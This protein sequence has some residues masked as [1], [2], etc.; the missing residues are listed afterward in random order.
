MLL[1]SARLNTRHQAP[2]TAIKEACGILRRQNKP[3]AAFETNLTTALSAAVITLCMLRHNRQAADLV[4][5]PQIVILSADS[6][7]GR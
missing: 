4:L 5:Q 1:T 2:F 6:R 3:S 7:T